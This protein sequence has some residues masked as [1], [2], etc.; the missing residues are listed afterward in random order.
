MPELLTYL[1][2]AVSVI[3][4]AALLMQLGRKD[5]LLVTM[6]KSVD[7]LKAI[8]TDL[9]KAQ[10]ATTTNQAHAQRDLDE[11]ARRVRHLEQAQVAHSTRRET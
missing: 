1:Q 10:V 2:L 6:A 7:E 8:T 4:V 3:C 11:I 9:V 5:Q